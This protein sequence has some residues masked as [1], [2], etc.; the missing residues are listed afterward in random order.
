MSSDAAPL[1]DVR[2]LVRLVGQG[3]FQR[4]REYARDAAVSEIE[5]DEESG[6]LSSTV[7][8]SLE[9]PYRCHIELAPARDG[10]HRPVSGNCS[11]AVGANCKH[12]AATL[13]EGNTIHLREPITSIAGVSR[14]SD[15]VKPVEPVVVPNWKEFYLY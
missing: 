12:V 3:A 11:C 9:N 7:R 8:G 5:W 14:G 13:L 6:L 15:L 4:G 1:V 2:D 10:Y